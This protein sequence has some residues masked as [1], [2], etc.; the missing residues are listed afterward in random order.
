MFLEE[1]LDRQRAI[2][3]KRIPE[4]KWQI[5]QQAAQAL[6]ESGTTKRCLKVGDT[7]LDFDLPNALGKSVTLRGLLKK[8][9]VVLSF[10]RGGW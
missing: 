2:S 3:R 8:G 4:D 10:Y 5:M 1:Q 9:P 6:A 7:A